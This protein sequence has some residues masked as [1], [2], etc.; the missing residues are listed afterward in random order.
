MQQV[1]LFVNQDMTVIDLGQND[2]FA[3]FHSYDYK[4]IIANVERIV[5]V[6]HMYYVHT[7]FVNPFK[8]VKSV[9]MLNSANFAKIK[10][11]K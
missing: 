6:G 11:V 4:V 2:C 7:D 1:R 10:W 3:N 8:S 5:N 9:F